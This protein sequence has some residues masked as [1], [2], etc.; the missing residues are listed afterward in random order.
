ML[1]F[2]LEV[3]TPTFIWTYTDAEDPLTYVLCEKPHVEKV[4]ATL[5]QSG[6]ELAYQI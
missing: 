1:F 6:K 5:I 4:E 2:D 3:E